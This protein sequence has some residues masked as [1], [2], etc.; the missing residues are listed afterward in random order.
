MRKVL[1]ISA[2]SEA[3]FY[4]VIAGSILIT[5]RR[6]FNVCITLSTTPMAL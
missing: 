2:T 3:Y 6:R 1:I 4:G 5:P